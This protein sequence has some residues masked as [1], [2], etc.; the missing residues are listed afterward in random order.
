MKK[1]LIYLLVCFSIFTFISCGD[2]EPSS[3]SGDLIGTWETKDAEGLFN[4]VFS[5]YYEDTKAYLQIK[6]DGT[7]TVVSVIVWTDEAVDY[8]NLDKKVQV[9]KDSC[10][11]HIEDGKIYLDIDNPDDINIANVMTYKCDKNT[12][13]LTAIDFY[14]ITVTYKRVSDS[15]IDKYL[16]N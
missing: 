16:N 11:W 1:S 8:L 10:K 12:L 7:W 4:D 5:S 3:G 6:A 9:E 13:Q 2:D 15:V 14:S